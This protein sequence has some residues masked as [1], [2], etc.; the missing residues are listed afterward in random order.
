MLSLHALPANEGDCLLLSWGDAGRPHRMLTDGGRVRSYPELHSAIKGLGRDPQLDVLVVTHIDGDHIEGIIR[1]MLDRAALRLRIADVWFNGYPQIAA[2][3]TLGA[4]QGEMLGAV[5][6]RDKLPWN[7][8]FDG[9]PIGV[10]SQG[11]LP[12]IPLPGGATATILSP[13]RAQLLTL[14]ANWTKVLRA[15]R[16]TPGDVAGALKRLAAQKRLAGLEAAPD[17]LGKQGEPDS[18]EANASSIAMLIEHEGHSV[19]MTGD[20]FGDVLAAGIRRLLKERDQSVL[21]VDVV[22]LPHHGSAGNV[23]DELLALIDTSRFVI[24]TNGAVYDHPDSLAIERVLRRP[25]RESGTTLHFNYD[26]DTTAPWRTAAR[27]KQFAQ[28]GDYQTVYPDGHTPGV[29]V[30]VVRQ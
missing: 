6:S 4:S 25:H 2:A 20:G 18:S 15:A 12:R 7:A 14:R 3:D 9:K 17:Q 27:R 5:L 28:Y 21:S 16:Q 1:L 24:S 23:T 13:G 26:S 10:P 19:L 22:K 30:D 8:A 29:L 11:A